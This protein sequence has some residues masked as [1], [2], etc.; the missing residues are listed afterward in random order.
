MADDGCGKLAFLHGGSGSRKHLPGK[1]LF[2]GTYF[3]SGTF[4][5]LA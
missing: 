5:G 4:Y 3:A 1:S 2:P